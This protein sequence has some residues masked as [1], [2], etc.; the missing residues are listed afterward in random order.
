M[1]KFTRIAG[2]RTVEDWKI[3]R[4]KILGDY[5]NSKNWKEAADFFKERIETR[6]FKPID[7]IINMR[8]TTGEG[9]SVVTLI[10]SLVEFLE[11]FYQGKIYNYNKSAQQKFDYYS[12]S[13]MF[14]EFLINHKPFELFFKQPVPNPT[15][16]IKTFADDFY[17]NV[18]CGLLHEAATKNGWVIRKHEEKDKNNSPKVFID[19]SHPPLKVIYRNELFNIIKDEF[20][21]DYQRQLIADREDKNKKKLRDNFGRRMDSLCEIKDNARWWE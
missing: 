15:K 17:S 12:S 11:S 9:F 5:N 10:C 21:P 16:K 19:L 13:N 18:R 1:D 3:L 20:V 14:K 4:T 2:K 7:R 6:Y 8:L